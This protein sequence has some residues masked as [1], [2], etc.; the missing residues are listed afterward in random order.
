MKKLLFIL[1]LFPLNSHSQSCTGTFSLASQEPS[2]CV[3]YPGGLFTKPIPNAGRGGPITHLITNSADMVTLL[4]GEVTQNEM[5]KL[6]IGTA[7]TSSPNVDNPNSNAAENSNP[8]YYGQ[9]SDPLWGFTNCTTNCAGDF[10]N[11]FQVHIPNNA[12]CSYLIGHSTG[13]DG[14]LDVWD[15]ATNKMV[16]IYCF[17]DAGTSYY[18]ARYFN[19]GNCCTKDMTFFKGVANSRGIKQDWDVP[20]F[21]S[22]RSAPWS[23]GLRISELLAGR[24]NHA[25]IVNTYCEK[26]TGTLYVFPAVTGGILGCSAVPISNTNRP[27]LGQHFF[28]DYTDAQIAALGV[29]TAK[30]IILT[31]GA[32]YGFYITDSCGVACM[33]IDEREGD[34]AYAVAGISNPFFTMPGVS[35][36]AGVGTDTPTNICTIAPMAGLPMDFADHIHVADECVA[37]GLAGVSGGCVSKTGFFF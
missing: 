23:T 13:G 33:N 34:T 30:K 31:A 28:L 4:V 3:P 5:F 32:H 16:R 22:I 17:N 19:S 15:Q 6:V 2:T 1:I 37:K 21:Y 26:D 35:C 20:N 27:V 7:G 25:L 8:L 36:T 9:S 12:R 11:S 24:I 14:W 10:N 29:S 18:N